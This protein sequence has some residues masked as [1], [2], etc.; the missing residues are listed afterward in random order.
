PALVASACLVSARLLGGRTWLTT[1]RLVPRG[2]VRC[3]SWRDSDGV[4]TPLPE[5]LSHRHGDTSFC[6]IASFQA[7]EA[8]RALEDPAWSLQPFVLRRDPRILERQP[9]LTQEALLRAAQETGTTVRVGYSWSIAQNRGEGPREIPLIDYLQSEMDQGIYDDAEFLEPSYAFDMGLK[10]DGMPGSEDIHPVIRSWNGSA[11]SVPDTAVA[12]H[13]LGGARSAVGWH[14][15]G[16]TVQMTVHGRKRWFLYPPGHYPPGDGPGG[17]FSLTDWLQL[18]YPTLEPA[19]RPLEFILE[20]GDAAYIPD[21]WYHAVVN[22]EDSVAVS[23]Q[24]KELS[25]EPQQFFKS[26]SMGAVSEVWQEQPGSVEELATAARAFL[27]RGAKNDLHARRVL[28]Y[29]LTQMDPEEAVEVILEGTKKDPFHVPTQFELASW[30]AS[31][32]KAGEASAVDTFRRVMQL[33]EPNL[34][35]NTRNQKAL[36]IL[37]KFHRVIG[38]EE[39]ADRYFDRLVK[40]NKLG[41]DR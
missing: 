33:W 4:Q 39:T 26:V 30:L 32:I 14:T 16:A 40:L 24:S 12:V 41:I 29:C 3:R 8:D 21:G 2:A 19:E 10:L 7:D 13:M 22:L 18:V 9:A 27:S 28:F 31:R 11:F 6:D 35:A 38:D 15:H 25:P 34:V 17:G 23:I 1:P 36:W 5:Y 37:N 20:A